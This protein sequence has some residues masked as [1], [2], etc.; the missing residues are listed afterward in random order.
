M[1]GVRL[2]VAVGVVTELGDLHRFDHPRKLMAYLGL[3]PS[4]Q[5]SG[6]KRQLDA[7]IAKRRCVTV[8]VTEG[9]VF[10]ALYGLLLEAIIVD[11]TCNQIYDLLILPVL[12]SLFSMI[13]FCK[14][15]PLV[16]S[17]T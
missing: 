12:L 11:R 8:P 5:S 15:R 9:N 1:R 16:R 14:V 10:S 3:V 13:F 7:I 4:E 2:L 6:G 17:H